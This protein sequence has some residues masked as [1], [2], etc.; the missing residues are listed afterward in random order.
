MERSK[1]KT[2]TLR[3]LGWAALYCDGDVID[4][5][6]CEREARAR[7]STYPNATVIGVFEL[8]EKLPNPIFLFDKTP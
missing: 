7:A 2:P 1:S 4:F 5:Y 8:L 6:F 3:Q